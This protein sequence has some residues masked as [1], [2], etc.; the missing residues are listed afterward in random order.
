MYYVLLVIYIGSYI[1][2][3]I[4][5]IVIHGYT[6]EF[7]ELPLVRMVTDLLFIGVPSPN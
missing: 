4:I 6:R 7:L 1:E 5:Y 2:S 3:Y